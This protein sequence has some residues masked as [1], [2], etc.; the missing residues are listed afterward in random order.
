MLCEGQFHLPEVYL[1]SILEENLSTKLD[2][3]SY[4]SDSQGISK[5]QN[6]EL[7]K[8]CYFIED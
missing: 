4:T 8:L 6:W 5:Q 1:E 3:K 2:G 7:V